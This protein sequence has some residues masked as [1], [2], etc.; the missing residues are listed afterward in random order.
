M[1]VTVIAYVSIIL[2]VIHAIFGIAQSPFLLNG[3]IKEHLEPM[4]EAFQ[5]Q[6]RQQQEIEN[7]YVNEIITG[8]CTVEEVSQL[9]TISISTFQDAGLQLHKW[10]SN[11]VQLEDVPVIKQVD[12]SNQ[13]YVKQRLRVKLNETKILGMH[14]DKNKDVIR[15][16]VPEKTDET[17]RGRLRFLASIF[18]HLGIVSPATLCG[19]ILYRE[20]CDLTIGWDKAITNDLLKKWTS[21]Q[22]N[23]L[24]K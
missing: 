16:S 5:E 23:Y 3:G 15:V 8:G 21:G 12:R 1:K 20:A 2:H 24:K 6:K 13:T 19:K 7:F 11:R 4:K 18:D 14:W 17:K 10:N 9:K 22:V